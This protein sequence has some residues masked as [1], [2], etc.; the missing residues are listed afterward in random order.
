MSNT[1]EPA[2]EMNLGWSSRPMAL[3]TKVSGTMLPPGIRLAGASL[4]VGS[5]LLGQ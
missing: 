2:A 4:S 5:A 3:L 1:T